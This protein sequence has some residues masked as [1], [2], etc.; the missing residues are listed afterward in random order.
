[1]EDIEKLARAL[2]RSI[3][4][5]P[6]R[7]E[8]YRSR[9]AEILAEITGYPQ[10]PAEGVDPIC[11]ETDE[12]VDL[13][14][15]VSGWRKSDGRWIAEDDYRVAGEVW[16]VHKADADPFPSRPHAHCVGGAKRFIG[17]K[18]HLGTAELYHGSRPLGR[19]LA[20]RN[21]E[22]LI[23]LIRPKF[24]GLILPLPAVAITPRFLSLDSTRESS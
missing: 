8:E 5:A 14:V 11:A 1:M 2:C 7:W 12:Y 10:N 23:E 21:F 9:A 24:P 20:P 3:G 15:G 6:E 4:A 19:V 17:C 16:R 18:L 22:R 13:C